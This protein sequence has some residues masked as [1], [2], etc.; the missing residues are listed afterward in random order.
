MV[1]DVTDASYDSLSLLDGFEW[2][3]DQ[4]GVGT[5]PPG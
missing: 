4:S 1:F 2:S 3:I 5:G